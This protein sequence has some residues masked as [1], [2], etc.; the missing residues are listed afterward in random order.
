MKPG[1]ALEKKFSKEMGVFVTLYLKTPVGNKLRGC[2]GY[3]NPE[4]S[5]IEALTDSAISAAA[6][7]PRF[8]QVSPQELDTIIIEVSIL[9]HPE[10]IQVTSPEEYFKKVKIGEDGLIV[11]WEYG[12]GLLLPQVAVEYDW[13]PKEFLSNTCVKAGAPEDLW[14]T[15]KV[16]IYRFKAIVF[17]EKSPKG[18]VVNKLKE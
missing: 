6:R 8:D 1:K 14:L 10:L 12:S 13:T 3:P 18:S 7:D 11:K 15:K 9:S 17:S 4:K 16:E 2:I 5:F